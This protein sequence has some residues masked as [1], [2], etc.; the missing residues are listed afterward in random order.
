[1]KAIALFGKMLAFSRLRINT[2]DIEAIRSEIK[3]TLKSNANPIPVVID[4]TVV[5]DLKALVEMLWSLNI[6]P[7]GVMAGELTEQANVLRLAIFPADGQRIDS[8]KVEKNTSTPLKPSATKKHTRGSVQNFGKEELELGLTSS[9]CD[10]VLRSG[11]S[12]QHLGGDLVVL[13]GVNRGADAITDSNLHVY[14][15]GLGRLV[16]GATGD[17]DARIFC[18]GF[19]PSLVSVAGTYCLHDDIPKDMIGKAVQVSYDEKQGL[20][21]TLMS[22]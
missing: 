7:I 9:V 12:L 21:F 4:S 5:L 1:M 22:N 16:A 20:V 10:S 15:R 6:Q 14:G 19:D 18:Q 13:G 11:Q 3:Q 2:D 17:K 8:L